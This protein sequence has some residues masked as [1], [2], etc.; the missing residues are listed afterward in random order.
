VRRE[1]DRAVTSYLVNNGG[2]G[3]LGLYEE[4]LAPEVVALEFRYFDGAELLDEWDSTAAKNLPLAVE[5]S[6]AVANPNVDR[7]EAAMLDIAT[8]SGEQGYRVYRLLVH[9]PAAK[10]LEQQEQEAAA[11]AAAQTG[12]TATGGTTTGGTSTTP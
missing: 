2:I 6:L 3:E 8:M 4:L 9:L 12:S 5:I 10:T 1:M 11:A 7:A